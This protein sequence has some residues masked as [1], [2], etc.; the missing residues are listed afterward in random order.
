VNTLV[1]QERRNQALLKVNPANRAGPMVHVE[2]IIPHRELVRV[3][4]YNPA[5][6]EIFT[7]VN[8][9]LNAGTYRYWWNTNTVPQGCYL[10]KMQS[11]SYSFVKNFSIIR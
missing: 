1:P 3:K 5:G 9:Q 2:C 7:I 6:R 4:I 10:V 8:K 11:V